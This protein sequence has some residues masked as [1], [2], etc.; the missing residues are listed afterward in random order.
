MSIGRHVIYYPEE[1][2]RDPEPIAPPHVD[3]PVAVRPERGERHGC[4]QHLLKCNDYT[5][6][7]VVTLNTG[8]THTP[9][10]ARS[11]R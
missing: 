1:S 4:H 10:T 3:Q 9:F 11:R 6:C 2:A 8:Y 7:D 5:S